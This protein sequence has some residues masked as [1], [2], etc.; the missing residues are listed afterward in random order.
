MDLTLLHGAMHI[1]ALG[2]FH[3]DKAAVGS[4]ELNRLVG[5]AIRIT[6]VNIDGDRVPAEFRE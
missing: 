6:I 3:A 5:V 1:P 4:N 2:L